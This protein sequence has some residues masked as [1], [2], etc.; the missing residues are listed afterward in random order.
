M[1]WPRC[2]SRGRISL[3][4]GNPKGNTSEWLLDPEL[5]YAAVRYRVYEKGDA[6]VGVE[7]RM[8][9]FRS[10][11]N[12]MLPFKICGVWGADPNRPV[13][14]ET[15]KVSTYRLNDPENTPDRYHIDWPEGTRIMDTRAGVAFRVEAGGLRY[16][17]DERIARI[18]LEQLSRSQAKEPNTGATTSVSLGAYVVASD[19]NDT[20]LSPEQQ[21]TV[22]PAVVSS[23]SNAWLWWC[24]VPSTA[25][26]AGLV[27]WRQ[28]RRRRRSPA[29]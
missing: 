17:D 15:I 3:R 29:N 26:I 25:L 27:L 2:S 19:Q 22:P 9:D 23:H 16:V 10:V 20:R 28:W 13:R 21:G 7:Y 1:V 12:L 14:T 5:G 8:E 18:A 4:G 6:K 11:D 24:I